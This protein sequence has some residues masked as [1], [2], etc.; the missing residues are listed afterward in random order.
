MTSRYT[1]FQGIH[2][3]FTSDVVNPV[4][5]QT[6]GADIDQALIR[7]ATLANDFSKFGSVIARRSAAQNITKATLT[8]ITFDNVT[9]DNGANSPLSNGAWWN[10]ANP[11]RL[12]A[13]VPCVVIAIGYGSLIWSGAAGSPSVFQVTVSLNGASASPGIQGSKYGPAST[14]SGQ[15]FSSAIS[16]WKLNA[17]DYLELKLFWTGTPAGPLPTETTSFGPRMSLMMV[18]LP[19]VP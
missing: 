8:A 7:T 17:A 1:P 10:A 9:N 4:D 15:M 2:Y 12:T 18:A 14:Q 5:V 16:M 3:P 11:T 19:S 13:P 6:T